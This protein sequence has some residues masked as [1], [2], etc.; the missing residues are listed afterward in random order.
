MFRIFKLVKD[1]EVDVKR[2][3]DEVKLFGED[4][5]IKWWAAFERVLDGLDKDKCI[6]EVELVAPIG[7][8]KEFKFKLSVVHEEECKW[9]I[10]VIVNQSDSFSGDTSRA[11]GR[12]ENG[13]E[14]SS[15]LRCLAM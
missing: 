2:G 11:M 10:Q 5:G 7:I 15:N 8:E 3:V 9:S 6:L 13:K 12:V 14:C 4:M 1:E